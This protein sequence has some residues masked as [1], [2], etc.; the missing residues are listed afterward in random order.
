M[1]TFNFTEQQHNKDKTTKNILL[2]QLAFSVK[3]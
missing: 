3:Y 2:S 1:L